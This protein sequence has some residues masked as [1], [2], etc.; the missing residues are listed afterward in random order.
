MELQIHGSFWP[1]SQSLA[2]ALPSMA[3]IQIIPQSIG[4]Y[5]RDLTENQE[6]L[7]RYEHLLSL[8]LKGQEKSQCIPLLLFINNDFS[9][10]Y[11]EQKKEKKK[12]TS[13]D[14]THKREI[15][16]KCLPH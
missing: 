13:D 9:L 10:K 11:K 14:N 1:A 16:L 12:K 6:L 3:L 5:N 4:E 15:P 7:L 2:E 8:L